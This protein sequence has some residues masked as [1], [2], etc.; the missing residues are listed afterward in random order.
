MG[1]KLVWQRNRD[2]PVDEE[3]KG[4]SQLQ[5]QLESTDKSSVGFLYNK[6]E[7]DKEAY[8]TGKKIDKDFQRKYLAEDNDNFEASLNPHKNDGPIRESDL[9]RKVREDPFALVKEKEAERLKKLQANPQKMA[10]MKKIM[11]AYLQ[12][13]KDDSSDDEETKKKSNNR[14]DRSRSRS[15]DR[16]RIRN[17]RASRD[18]KRKRSRSR[19]KSREPTKPG[20]GLIIPGG[21]KNEKRNRGNEKYKSE[22]SKLKREPE[23]YRRKEEHGF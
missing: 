6:Q 5:Q 10:R 2:G 20:Y 9:G 1:S 7:L 8:Q 13:N 21:K 3:P 12:S 22:F 16:S 11:E 4:P 19:S 23:G 15:R 18:E 14:R 17:R